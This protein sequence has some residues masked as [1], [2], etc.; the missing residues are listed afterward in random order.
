MDKRS[1]KHFI[2]HLVGMRE[3]SRLNP[4]QSRLRPK[5]NQ[6]AIQETNHNQRSQFFAQ[7]NIEKSVKQ[8]CIKLVTKQRS[9]KLKREKTRSWHRILKSINF[10]TNYTTT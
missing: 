5:Q 6:L 3:I 7:L 10:S 8:Q 1:F 2:T 9:M 4:K